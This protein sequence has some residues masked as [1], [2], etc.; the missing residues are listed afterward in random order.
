MSFNLTINPVLNLNLFN[1][2]FNSLCVLYFVYY[3]A[4][5]FCQ[6]TGTDETA[7]QTKLEPF[8]GN[9]F[10]YGLNV[11]ECAWGRVEH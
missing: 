7:F 4:R 3:Q 10:R 6:V 11:L 1:F 5:I 2:K 8:W 9:M